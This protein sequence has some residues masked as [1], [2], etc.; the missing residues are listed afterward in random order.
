[1]SSEIQAVTIIP[2]RYASSRFPGK[3]LAE[4]A[5]KPMIQHTYE[6]VLQASRVSRILVAT[7]DD[8]IAQ[9]VVHFGGDVV[10]TSPH[11]ATGTD[12]LAE[13]AETLTDDLI[14]NVQGD[15]PLIH[16][17]MID[18]V[19][20]LLADEPGLP[21]STLKTRIETPDDIFNPAITKVVT[22]LNGYALYFSKGPIP[23]CRNQWGDFARRRA[24]IPDFVPPQVACHVGLYAYRRAFLL[25]YANLPPTPL[26]Q[27]EQLEQLRALEH[28]YRIKVADTTHTSIGVDTPEDLEKARLAWQN[29]P[30]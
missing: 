11:H 20:R 22:D 27:L 7:D 4:I 14:V 9:T 2:A 10:M 18:T 26:E 8:R 3:A 5:G 24:K 16:P 17:E 19:V 25:R 29:R 23:F 1:M 12:R 28:G 13:V 30:L 15:E 21:M 6:R